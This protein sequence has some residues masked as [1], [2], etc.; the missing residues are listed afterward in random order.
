MPQPP[1]PPRHTL[2]HHRPCRFARSIFKSADPA[3]RAK[4]IVEAVANFEDP[5]VLAK[6]SCDLGAPMVGINC[7][8]LK[9]RYSGREGGG[10]SEPPAKKHAPHGTW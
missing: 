10:M 6:V 4:A 9:V 1:V 5:K 3:K 8:D 7:D 2:A